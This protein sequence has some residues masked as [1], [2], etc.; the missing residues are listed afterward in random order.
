MRWPIYRENREN[1]H[2]AKISHYTVSEIKD[3]ASKKRRGSKYGCAEQPLFPSIP[4]S[5]VVIDTLHLLLRISD[6]L[7]NLLLADLEQHDELKKLNL[8][9]FDHSKPPYMGKFQAFLNDD[10]GIPLEIIINEKKKAKWRD[11]MGPEK[12]ILLQEIIIPTLFPELSKVEKQR[13]IWTQFYHLYKHICAESFPKDDI[14]HLQADLKQWMTIFL[15]VYQ[16]RHVTPYMHSLVCHIPEFLTI[17]GGNLTHFT[18]QGM[19]KLNDTST[20]Y[21]FR[22]TN[23]HKKDSVALS[24]LLLKRNRVKELEDQGNI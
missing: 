15:A 22:A 12:H 14:D 20:K 5:H 7:M 23:H 10:C 21:Y 6:V 1:L 11:L 3:M 18:Q 2:Y 9:V 19:E 16:S 4:I 13:E 17:Y 8:K 24:Q